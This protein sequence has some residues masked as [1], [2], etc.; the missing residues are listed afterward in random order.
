MK[1]RILKEFL[2]DLNM[3]Q[4]WRSWIETFMSK[5]EYLDMTI[6][7]DKEIFICKKE[8]GKLCKKRADKNVTDK[9]DFES[10]FA[11]FLAILKQK[12]TL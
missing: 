12:Q 10:F 11:P 5:G 9:M 6:F 4:E 2:E 8:E 3:P 1:G 7:D